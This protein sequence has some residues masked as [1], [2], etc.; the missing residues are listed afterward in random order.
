MKTA[1]KTGYIQFFTRYRAVFLLLIIAGLVVA[2]RS[3]K[4]DKYEDLVFYIGFLAMFVGITLFTRFGP[5]REAM[6][7]YDKIQPKGFEIITMVIFFLA[8]IYVAGSWDK[9]S[10]E[11]LTKVSPYIIVP[12][13]LYLF[14]S[15]IILRQKAVKADNENR[16]TEV[17]V[18]AQAAHDAKV[19]NKAKKH[20]K[21]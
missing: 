3:D 9:A 14:F 4:L 2:M 15:S 1:P 16:P 11:L 6:L 12:S 21:K 10:I 13:L 8:G 17:S 7:K 19:T 18:L 20:G 5:G